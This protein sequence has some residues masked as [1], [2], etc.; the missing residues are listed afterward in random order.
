[1]Q[2]SEWLSLRSLGAVAAYYL[3]P[4]LGDNLEKV[5]CDFLIKWNIYC[6]SAK[7][8]IKDVKAII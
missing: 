3:S 7:R 2:S 5:I 4:E 1:M 6:L 8:Q